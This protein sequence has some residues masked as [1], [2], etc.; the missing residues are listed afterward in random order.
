MDWT[1][2]MREKA[3]NVRWQAKNPI[4]EFNSNLSF[5]SHFTTRMSFQISLSHH[6]VN[7]KNS[8][9]FYSIT[10]RAIMLR[11]MKSGESAKGD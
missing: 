8:S 11:A 4:K 2:V 6:I 3:R 1:N 9:C 5:A 7:L 10:I